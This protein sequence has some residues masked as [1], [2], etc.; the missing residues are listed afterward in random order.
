MELQRAQNTK[1]TN[2]LWSQIYERDFNNIMSQPVKFKKPDSALK[3]N[4]SEQ[5]LKWK[6]L[7]K[8]A[9]FHKPVGSTLPSLE[10]IL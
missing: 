4:R 7:L 6:S 2:S 9:P 5:E 8:P 10:T 3:R 1:Q